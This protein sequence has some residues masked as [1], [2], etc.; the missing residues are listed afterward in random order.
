MHIREMLSEDSG[1][2]EE[3]LRNAWGSTQVVSRGVI[4]QADDLPAIV[5]LSSKQEKIGLLTYAIKESNLEIVTLNSLKQ[6]EGIGTALIQKAE[7]IAVSEGCI[8]IWVITTNDNRDAIEFYQKRGF[9]IRA[10]HK[11]AIE[12]SRKLKP[13]IPL[14]GL[15]GIPIRDEIELEKL[16]S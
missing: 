13:E 7:E 2:V 3:V 16:I 4:H 5:A 12:H 11:N 9:Q 10:I 15:N 14:I 8:R 6:G 1:F